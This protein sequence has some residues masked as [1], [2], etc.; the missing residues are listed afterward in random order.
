M[1]RLDVCEDSARH[2]FSAAGSSSFS[3][4]STYHY[5]DIPDGKRLVV[6][7]VSMRAEVSS[8]SRFVRGQ[9]VTAAGGWYIGFDFAPR[10]LGRSVGGRDV[11]VVSQPATLYAG[12]DYFLAAWGFLSSIGGGGTF[13]TSVSGYLIDCNEDAPCD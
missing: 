5:L 4:G 12:P 6:E 9:L 11:Y 13:R 2:A 10:Y 8:E 3:Y 7:F 1:G